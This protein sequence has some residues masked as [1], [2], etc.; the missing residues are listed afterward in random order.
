MGDGPEYSDLYESNLILG[1]AIYIL[2]TG[3][4]P[5]SASMNVLLT[6]HSIWNIDAAES[7]H[8]VDEF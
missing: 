8:C 5:H 6:A 4:H 7:P 1:P 2:F 3:E